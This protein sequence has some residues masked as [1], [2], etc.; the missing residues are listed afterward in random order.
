MRAALVEVCD[1]LEEQPAVADRR[2][3]ELLQVFT[4]Q[5][6]QRTGVDLV[7]AERLYV[8]LQPELSQPRANVQSG[9]SQ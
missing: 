5:T 6:G 2:D 7:L 9:L 1:R 3:P 4:G 8:A